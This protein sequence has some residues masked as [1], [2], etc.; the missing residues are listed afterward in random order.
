MAESALA[1][2]VPEVEKYVAPVRE[3]LDPSARLG[4]PAHITLLYPFV[5]PGE[6]DAS[7]LIALG[8]AFSQ[9]ASFSFRLAKLHHFM[10]TLYLAPE[11]ADPFMSLTQAIVNQFPRYLPYGG[12]FASVVPHLTVARGSRD[13]LAF[14]ER[15]LFGTLT[16]AGIEAHCREVVLIENSSGRWQPMHTFRLTSVHTM[17]G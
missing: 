12:Q 8:V 2:N 16:A 15:S 13:T 6:I 17:D 11:P 14:A 4:A 5:E 3:K 7:T 10:D 1:V 9:A